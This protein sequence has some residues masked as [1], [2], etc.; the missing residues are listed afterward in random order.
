MGIGLSGGIVV[1]ITKFQVHILA[2]RPKK[3]VVSSVGIMEQRATCLVELET[4]EGIRGFGESWVNFP[5]WAVIERRATLLQGVGPLVL[6]ADETDIEEIHRRVLR[7]L[8]PIGRQ[9]GAVGP[10]WQAVSAVD[11]ALW[12]IAGQRARQPV[13][14]LL[15][16]VGGSVPVYASGLGPQI[17]PRIVEDCLDRGI[18]IFKLKGGRDLPYDLEQVKLLRQI[19]GEAATIW[20]DANQG[21]E[22]VEQAQGAIDTLAE[23]GVTLVEEPIAADD[24]DGMAQLAACSPIPLAAGENVYGVA[25]FRRWAERGALG[26]AQPDVSKGGGITEARRVATELRQKF[27]LP[28]APHYLGGAV[29]LYATAHFFNGVPGGIA[30]ELDTN[31]NPLREDLVE[32]PPRVRDGQLEL[33]SGPGLGITFRRDIWRRCQRLG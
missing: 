4:R 24:W 7:A 21:W 26:V 28:Y 25:Q 27:G 15:G 22:T 8:L 10:I 31:P 23:Q 19:V 30:V 33:P 1:P 18:R 20:L 17:E 13:W 29:G 32:P 12:D 11:Q 6:G 14:R 3:P 16:G 2:Y 5:A 9:W